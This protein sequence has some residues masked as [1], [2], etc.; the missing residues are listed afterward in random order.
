MTEGD[1]RDRDEKRMP[2]VSEKL[3]GKER[4]GKG[5][6]DKQ[7]LLMQFYFVVF[8]KVTGKEIIGVSLIKTV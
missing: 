2:Q 7:Q 4:Y 6:D 8:E 1:R 5:W 3:E